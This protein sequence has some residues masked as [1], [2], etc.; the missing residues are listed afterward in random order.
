MSANGHRYKVV[1]S[2][3]IAQL[4]KQL[5]RAAT[6][7]DR[8]GEFIAALQLLNERLQID[9]LSFGEPLYQLP[10]LKLL[11]C[12]QIVRP[13]AMDY[14]VHQELPLVFLKDVRLI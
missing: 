14:G 12:I 13:I 1:V 9:P 10:N 3:N 8:G 4:I 6:E 7:D 2:G 5:H 11:V